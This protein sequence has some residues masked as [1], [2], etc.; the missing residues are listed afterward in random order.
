MKILINLGKGLL[1]IALTMLLAG[2]PFIIFVLLPNNEIVKQVFSKDATDVLGYYGTVIGGVVTVL[3]IYWTLNYESKK[4]KEERESEKEKLNEERKKN[5]LPIL[6]FT[7]KPNCRKVSFD[8]IEFIL[9]NNDTNIDFDIDINTTREDSIDEI[10]KISK[11]PSKSHSKKQKDTSAKLIYEYGDL[12]IENVGLG[13]AILSSACLFR[14]HNFT[15]VKNLKS[16]YTKNYVIVPGRKIILKMRIICDDINS[17]DS[18]EIYFYDPYY[19]S[20]SYRI[21]FKN[22][23][24]QHTNTKTDI[25][26][27][28]V[29]VLPV[30]E[31]EE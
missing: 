16:K 29:Q 28:D 12:E 7:F 10:A 22:V 20:Y 19:N 23:Y 25:N 5:S 8:N 11:S 1:I 17:G 3:G 2:A 24:K 6:R 30:A 4:L 14:F 26:Q 9:K 31:T 27:S 18:L 15:I 13:I 21:L